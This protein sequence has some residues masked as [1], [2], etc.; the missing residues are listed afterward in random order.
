MACLISHVRTYDNESF[1]EQLIALSL[2]EVHKLQNWD[3]NRIPDEKKVDEIIDSI[4]NQ[5]YSN[6]IIHAFANDDKFIVYD[7]SHRVQAIQTLMCSP[8]YTKAVDFFQNK[9]LLSVLFCA[10]IPYIIER[11]K[12]INQATPV[13]EFY[14]QPMQQSTQQ[15]RVLIPDCIKKF[16]Q[17]YKCSKTSQRPHLPSYNA[18]QL[19][20]ELF[21]LLNQN[22]EIN[23]G[24]ELTSK[25]LIEVFAIINTKY[26]A[27]LI[28]DPT[29]IKNGITY[30]NK[31]QIVNCFIFLKQW[32]SDFIPILNR[33]GNMIGDPIIV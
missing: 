16:K 21:D 4:K 33:I 30:V 19:E 12:A 11:Y 14:K 29:I 3:C 20:N 10:P 2:E 23:D 22:N 17:I 9:I 31:A 6:Q 32:Q 15:L 5:T 8:D 26:R 13:P 25:L 7:G 18:F 24:I 27:E 28:Q 1:E